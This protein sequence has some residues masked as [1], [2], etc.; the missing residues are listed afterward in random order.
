[1]PGVLTEDVIGHFGGRYKFWIIPR[2]VQGSSFRLYSL[3][4][5]AGYCFSNDGT[6]GCR[7]NS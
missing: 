1:M 2:G 5:R 7:W 3:S 4:G 6:E